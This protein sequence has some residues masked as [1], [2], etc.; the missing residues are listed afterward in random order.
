VK[1]EKNMSMHANQRQFQH[2]KPFQHAKKPDE[3]KIPVP[4]TSTNFVDHSS[5]S[6][7]CRACEL[8]DNEEGC[9][10]FARTAYIYAP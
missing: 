5:T 7:Y 4:M 1:M 8:P 6:H 3:Q 2:K 9:V 10:V